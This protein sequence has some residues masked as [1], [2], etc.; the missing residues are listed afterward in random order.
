[1]HPGRPTGSYKQGSLFWQL[2]GRFLVQKLQTFLHVALYYKPVKEFC[3]DEL[4]K[5]NI[6]T[7]NVTLRDFS[8]GPINVF[9]I[10]LLLSCLWSSTWH[11]CAWMKQVAVPVNQI[12]HADRFSHLLRYDSGNPRNASSPSCHLPA[13]EKQGFPKAPLPINHLFCRWIF[14]NFLCYLMKYEFCMLLQLLYLLDIS[15]EGKDEILVRSN[16]CGY[17]C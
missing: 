4:L 9:L 1:M 15:E 10:G 14:R 6:F 12:T 3:A 5:W 13:G 11:T 8:R 7:L 17:W 2:K 16:S